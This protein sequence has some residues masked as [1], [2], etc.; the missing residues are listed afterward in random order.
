MQR[1]ETD[2]TK[3]FRVSSTFA[4]PDV[5][6]SL[7]HAPEAVFAAASVD[8]GLYRNPDNRIPAEDLGRLF[9]HAARITAREDIALRVVSDFRPSGLGLVGLLV[10]EG[11]DIDTALRNLVRLLRY[12]TLA[13]YP[14]FSIAG[15]TAMLKFDLRYAD[16]AGAGFILEGATGI[17]HRFLRQLCGNGWKPEEVHLSRRAP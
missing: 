17:I 15:P 2:Q 6:R 3:S 7:G 10:A 4:M 9:V 16:F 5:I 12:N 1:I 11:P 8:P 13:G 14:A